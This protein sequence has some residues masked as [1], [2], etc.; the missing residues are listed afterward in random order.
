MAHLFYTWWS[1]WHAPQKHSYLLPGLN[2]GAVTCSANMQIAQYTDTC[3][4][5]KG[6]NVYQ[7]AGNDST[8]SVACAEILKWSPWSGSVWINSFTVFVPLHAVPLCDP[9]A[10]PWELIHCSPDRDIGISCSASHVDQSW[11]QRPLCGLNNNRRKDVCHFVA[12]E[13]TFKNK[14]RNKVCT[15]EP[16][17]L[18]SCPTEYYYRKWQV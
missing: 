9:S 15:R 4:Y 2:L 16:H 17:F 14:H 13:V 3:W 7:L 18:L 8:L 6:R 1:S 12:R 11:L 10:D 5:S